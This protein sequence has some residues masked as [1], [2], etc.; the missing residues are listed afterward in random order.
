[1]FEKRPVFASAV[2]GGNCPAMYDA[3]PVPLSTTDAYGTTAPDPC[4]MR[5]SATP[6]SNDWVAIE[7]T[8]NCVCVKFAAGTMINFVPTTLPVPSLIV[9]CTAIG[10]ADVVAARNP[11]FVRDCPLLTMP[12]MYAT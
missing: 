3:A 10:I 9:T 4:T 5:S 11:T 6:V 1:M 8:A 2:L 12:G 7:P